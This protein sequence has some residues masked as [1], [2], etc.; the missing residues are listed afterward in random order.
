MK[1]QIIGYWENFDG[2]V[3]EIAQNHITRLK[4]MLCDEI[5]KA[6]HTFDS[7]HKELKKQLKQ[8]YKTRRNERF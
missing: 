4:D 3:A 5:S 7:F 6:R 1:S 8:L 2:N